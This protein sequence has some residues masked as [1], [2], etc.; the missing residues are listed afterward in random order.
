MQ[1]F[2]KFVS[3]Y[4][5]LF[6]RNFSVNKKYKNR[7]K[8]EETQKYFGI[9]TFNLTNIHKNYNKILYNTIKFSP[10]TLDLVIN[11]KKRSSNLEKNL[12]K[13]RPNTGIYIL[14][15]AQSSEIVT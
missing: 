11:L 5:F 6:L 1:K 4:N 13:N 9:F 2:T 7:K 10:S 12:H 3:N 15:L 14:K 8:K